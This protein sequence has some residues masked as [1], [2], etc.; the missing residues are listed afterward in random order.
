[1]KKIILFDRRYI[2]IKDEKMPQLE[3]ALSDHQKFSITAYDGREYLLDPRAIL[4]VEP[5]GREDYSIPEERRIEAPE[6]KKVDTDSPG[7]Q[8]FLRA[9]EKLM[10]KKSI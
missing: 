9:K 3:E 5:A 7:Y 6:A 8:S 4:V 1:M 10:R 2:V